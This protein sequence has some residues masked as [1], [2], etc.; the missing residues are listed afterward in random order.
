MSATEAVAIASSGTGPEGEK[1]Q[2]PPAGEG[3]VEGTPMA[4]VTEGDDVKVFNE[5]KY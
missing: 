1:S 4:N 2:E 3:S 5:A